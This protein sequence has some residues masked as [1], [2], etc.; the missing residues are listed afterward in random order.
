TFFPD[1]PNLST[2]WFLALLQF[3]QTICRF[4]M[5]FG[6]VHQTASEARL[7]GVIDRLGIPTAHEPSH[8]P[9]LNFSKINPPM[10]SSICRLLMLVWKLQEVPNFAPARLGKSHPPDQ[11]TL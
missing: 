10:T 4:S 6:E 7:F 9:N 5:Q 11:N 3:L 2:V 1:F 8:L